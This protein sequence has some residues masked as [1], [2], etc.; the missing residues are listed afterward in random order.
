MNIFNN[1]KNNDSALESSEI[2][3][4]RASFDMKVNENKNQTYTDNSNKKRD[5]NK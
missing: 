5:E 1:E 3:N 2:K 4:T